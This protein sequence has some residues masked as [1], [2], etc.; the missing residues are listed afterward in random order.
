[1]THSKMLV[2]DPFGA[3][4][5]VVTGSHNFS[6]A[7]SGI[8][9]DNFV[10]IEGNAK[11]AQAYAVNCMMTYQHYRWRQYLQ[12]SARKHLPAFEFLNDDSAAWQHRLTSK[13]TKADQAFWL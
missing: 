10:V 3:K 12:E 11:L 1:M 8:N 4:P 9:D 6:G 2:I 7:A 5:I 13:T